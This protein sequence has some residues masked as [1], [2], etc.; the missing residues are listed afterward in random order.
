MLEDHAKL[1]A[2]LEGVQ[3]ALQDE[4]EQSAMALGPGKRADEL[5][6]RGHT[7]T[8]QEKLAEV[9]R[10]IGQRYGVYTKYVAAG[11]LTRAEAN[12]RIAIMEAISDDYREQVQKEQLL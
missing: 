8:A 5:A 7:F 1:L 6:G 10:E 2:T 11:L 9:K 4:I 3:E 12:R